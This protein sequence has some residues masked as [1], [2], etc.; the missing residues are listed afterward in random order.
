MTSVSPASVLAQ[1]TASCL[2]EVDETDGCSTYSCPQLTTV[3]ANASKDAHMHVTVKA[4]PR[5]YTLG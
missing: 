3:D 5:H 1:V 4:S 2:D